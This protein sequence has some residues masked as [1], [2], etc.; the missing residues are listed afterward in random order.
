MCGVNLKR[1]LSLPVPAAF[2]NPG[3]L[4]IGKS[5]PRQ[6]KFA[7]RLM[8]AAILVVFA[9]TTP[10]FLS[11]QALQSLLTTVSFIGCVAVGMSLIT[12]SGNILS[13]SLGAT[14]G[15]SALMLIASANHLG[16][17]AALLI[18]LLFGAMIGAAQGI[19][20][21]YLRAN[22]IIVTIATSV[23][24][25]GV[26]QPVTGN[27]SFYASAPISDALLV[28]R[29]FGMPF[30]FV[31]FLAV[32]VVCQILLSFTVFGRNIFMVGSSFRAARAA[33]LPSRATTVGAY[34]F[35]GLFSSVTGI[36]LAL[37]Y[38][39]AGME[40]GL[41]Y[42]YSAIAAV[43]VGGSSIAGGHGSAVRTFAGMMI[44]G[45]V[46]V[47][48]LLRG[49]RQEWQYLITGAIVLGVIMLNSAARE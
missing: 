32:L 48:L 13:L 37:R 25:Y 42:D 6:I 39:R 12:I 19:L 31:T 22:P 15:A 11:A 4:R 36:L 24:I 38:G 3:T 18:A 40:F 43:L 44:I 26:A 20:I 2:S 8:V 47:V 34:C 14:V 28:T 16:W 7:L 49:F 17:P 30:E 10:G 33:G 23:F 35:A 45:I 1:L 29:W 41:G 21:G 9:L 5:D 27:G 46:Q